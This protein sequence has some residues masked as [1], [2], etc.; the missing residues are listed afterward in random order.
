MPPTAV[1][2][3][4]EPELPGSLAELGEEQQEERPARPGSGPWC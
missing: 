1:I 4:A 3:E 2:V